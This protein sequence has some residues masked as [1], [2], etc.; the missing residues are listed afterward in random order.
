MFSLKP[1]GR[2]VGGSMD[3]GVLVS[4]CDEECVE[5]YPAGSLV[6]LP[7]RK[8]EYLA[9]V[10][11]AKLSSNLQL[12]SA[13]GL[14]NVPDG[15]KDK[16][17]KLNEGLLRGQY[18]ELA[19]IAQKPNGEGPPRAHFADTMPGFYSMLVEPTQEKLS[20]FF[21]KEDGVRLWNV[22]SPKAPKKLQVEIPIDVSKLVELSFGIFGKSGTGKTFLGNLLAGYIVQYDQALSRTQGRR[23]KLLIFDMHS[24]YALELKSAESPAFADGVAKIFAH[25]FKRYTPDE[26][27]ANSR[28]LDALRVKLSSLDVDDLSLIAPIFG[29]TDT[30]V[31][32]LT[33]FR[34]VLRKEMG[35]GDLWIWGLVLDNHSEEVLSTSQEGRAVLDELFRR[36]GLS[37]GEEF[38]DALLKEIEERYGHGPRVSFQ[39][40]APKLKPLIWYPFTEQCD[41]IEEIVSELLSEEG[42]HVTISLGRYERDTPLYMVVAN[43][44]ARR[45]YEKA[46][47]LPEQELRVR[48]VI[49]LEE[50]HNFLGAGVYQLSPFGLIAREMRKRGVTLCVIDQRPSELDRDVVSMLWTSFVFS[51]TDRSDISSAMYGS[52]RPE[53]FSKIIPL[54]KPKEALIYGEAVKFPVALEVEDYKQAESRFRELAD[55]SLSSLKGR[56]A[57]LRESGLL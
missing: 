15:V 41:T 39:S 57:M 11:D 49:F 40:Q 46:L 45:L 8:N 54:L 14:L 10:T 52:P 36:S 27:L 48:V 32:H 31:N 9:M 29:V 55:R 34:Y 21:E 18:L 37:S 2:V 43:L 33:S 17:A 1:L 56:E 30:F 26:D 4:L 22:G 6:V 28:R 5:D 24:E 19:L 53:L 35:L 42:R 20:A 38:R 50:A 7:S 13:I 51:L 23:V 44:I 16:I 25:Q 47:Q 12:T 3:Q